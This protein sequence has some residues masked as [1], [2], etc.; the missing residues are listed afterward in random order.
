MFLY[1][2]NLSFEGQQKNVC[3]SSV[4]FCETGNRKVQV[5]TTGK[6]PERIELLDEVK[7]MPVRR[8]IS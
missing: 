7:L 2:L 4:S 3:Q 1:L 8:E 6:I 5:Y